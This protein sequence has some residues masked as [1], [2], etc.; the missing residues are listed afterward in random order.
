MEINELFTQ[1]TKEADRHVLD[2]NPD[3]NY[4]GREDLVVEPE[5]SEF[6]I[7]RVAEHIAD[8]VT[9]LG[10]FWTPEGP[11]ACFRQA[12]FGEDFNYGEWSSTWNHKGER[13]EPELRSGWNAAFL[14]NGSEGMISMPRAVAYEMVRRGA[15]GPHAV[16][17]NVGDFKEGG[18]LA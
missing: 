9:G 18:P 17:K 5:W 11:E 3:E 12:W 15:I 1:W 13:Q 6:L 10:Q 8:V 4:D 2:R 7:R 16:G 14:Y